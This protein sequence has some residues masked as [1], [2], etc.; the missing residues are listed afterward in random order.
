MSREPVQGSE[1]ERYGFWEYDQFP[2]LLS[3]RVLKGPHANGKCH[4]EGFEGF[5]FKCVAIVAGADGRRL[6][7][8]LKAARSDHAQA[9]RAM[10][11][12][13]G[14]RSDRLRAA[15]KAAAGG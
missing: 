10:N 2:Y 12:A 15:I 6:H 5:S 1:P 4:I 8:E 3:G 9:T 11:E 13:W 14:A 7:Q